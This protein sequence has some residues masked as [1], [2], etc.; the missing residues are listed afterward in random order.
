MFRKALLSSAALLLA[1]SAA[2]AQPKNVTTVD[3]NGAKLSMITGVSQGKQQASK[4][5]YPGAIYSNLDTKYANGTFIPW[6]AYIFCGP[7]TSFC[8]NQVT[9]FAYPFTTG[10]A[11][12]QKVKGFDVALELASGTGG[13]TVCLESDSGGV[14]SGT[15]TT[16]TSVHFAASSMTGW[17]TFGPTLNGTFPSQNLSSSTQYWFVAVADTGT[18]VAAD[19]EDTDF[20]NPGNFGEQISG[21]W[22]NFSTAGQLPAFAAIK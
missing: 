10:A 15:C 6:Q 12:G 14:P 8:N 17:G 19:L 16:G 2:F 3:I 22:Y 20:V 21:N 18:A 5:R 7:T 1:S 9:N 11:S 13:V 4:V